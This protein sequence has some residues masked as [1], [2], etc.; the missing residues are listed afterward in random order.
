MRKRRVIQ[1]LEEVNRRMQK[2]MAVLGLT[3]L[4]FGLLFVIN[5]RMSVNIIVTLASLLLLV[6]GILQVF[7]FL[8]ADEDGKA[9]GKQLGVAMSVGAAGAFFLIQQEALSQAMGLIAS[10]LFMYHGGF[11]FQ[12]AISQYRFRYERWWVALLFGLASVAGGVYATVNPLGFNETFMRILGVLMLMLA[13]FDGYG[14]LTGSRP[15]IRG[16]AIPEDDVLTEEES[17]GLP[18]RRNDWRK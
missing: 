8:R 15:M 1:N 6:I 13:V 5:P 14:M 11:H 18:A 17:N 10:L 16:S 4:V 3:A 12:M 7:D 9:G 2:Q